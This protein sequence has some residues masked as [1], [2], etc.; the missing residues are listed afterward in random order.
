MANKIAVSNIAKRS[1]AGRPKGSKNKVTATAKAI[2]EE[3]AQG[4]GGADR[5]LAWARE[6]PEN[7]RAF[8]TN[9]FPKLMPLQ[10]NGPGD[11]GEHVHKIVT[12]IVYPKD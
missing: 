2:I 12:E 8:W 11:D 7:E 1:G 4:L 3:A 5:L 6:A 10:V 9:V